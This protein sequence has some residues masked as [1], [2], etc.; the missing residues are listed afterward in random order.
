VSNPLDVGEN[1]E[2]A[3]DFP[4]RLS[5]LFSVCP[6]LSMLFQH[7]YMAHALFPGRLSNHC[8]GHRNTFL[9]FAQNLMLVA[10]V[11]KIMDITSYLRK[12]KGRY[13]QRL[14]NYRYPKLFCV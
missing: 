5:R 10:L 11:P 4:L 8:Q 14:R 2:L 9:R 13:A 12:L 6:E 3:L 1:D 7:L